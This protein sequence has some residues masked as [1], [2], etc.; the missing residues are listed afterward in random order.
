MVP[1]IAMAIRTICLYYWFRKDCKYT[2]CPA[3]PFFFNVHEE[4]DIILLLCVHMETGS[5]DLVVL[6]ERGGPLKIKKNR[7][8]ATCSNL[9]LGTNKNTSGPNL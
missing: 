1:A 4:D 5:L 3:F 6:S 9:Q 8:T 2:I 7:A